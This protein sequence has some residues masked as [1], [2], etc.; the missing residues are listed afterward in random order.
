MWL[1]C[2]DVHAAITILIYLDVCTT[3]SHA[4]YPDICYIFFDVGSDWH[5]P[6]GTGL[7]KCRALIAVITNKYITSHYCTRYVSI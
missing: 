5:G 7:F 2:M 3:S 6:V 4:I 1:L